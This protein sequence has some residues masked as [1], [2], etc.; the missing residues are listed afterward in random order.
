MDEGKKAVARLTCKMNRSTHAAGASG[1]YFC[2]ISAI[3]AHNIHPKPRCTSIYARFVLG[4]GAKKGETCICALYVTR[5]PQYAA[6]DTDTRCIGKGR[7][8]TAEGLEGS[9]PKLHIITAM[10]CDGYFWV[11]WLVSKPHRTQIEQLF[12]PFLLLPCFAT[13]NPVLLTEKR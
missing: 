1:M 4:L 6:L 13:Q 3:F 11:F 9:R 12:S 7:P 8:T 5:S 2:I 10:L